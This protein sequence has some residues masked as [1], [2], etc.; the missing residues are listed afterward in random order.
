MKTNFLTLIS[1]LSLAAFLSACSAPSPSASAIKEF[2]SKKTDDQAA[3]SITG[4]RQQ[5][6]RDAALSVGA[7][8][9]LAWRA[10]QINQSVTRYESSLDR[11]FN[12]HAMLLENNVLPP[13]LIEGRQI[14]EQNSLE[15]I[16]LSDRSF[17]IVSQAH[18]V[19]MPPT[20][21]D[22]LLMK[23]QKPELP[24]ASLMPRNDSE[25]KVWDRY[26]QEGWQAGI[27]QADSIFSENLGRLKRDYQ[28]MILYRS[29][30]AQQMVSPPYIA[31]VNLGVTGND[32]ELSVNDR[33]YKITA[34]PAFKYQ[35]H[36]EEWQTESTPMSMN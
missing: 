34:L 6:L 8:G 18:F 12:F 29:L 26:V 23:F 13:V 11:I 1:T 4:I 17:S 16:R 31:E 19:S 36:G 25:R 15:V 3:F 33:I 9:G 14:Y 32:S 22:Y 21:R 35:G 7:R 27:S 28:G 30:L 20:W 24:D 2:Q 10:Q 5:S